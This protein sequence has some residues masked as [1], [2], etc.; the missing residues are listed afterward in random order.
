MR[1]IS[2]STKQFFYQAQPAAQFI[3]K[4]PMIGT[5]DLNQQFGAFRPATR[6]GSQALR[7]SGLAAHE[8][9]RS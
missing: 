5:A 9:L 1:S 7:S 2:S 6:P 4:C 8:T 3:T